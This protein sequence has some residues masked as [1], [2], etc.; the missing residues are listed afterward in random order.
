MTKVYYLDTNICIFYMRGKNQELRD[1]IDA[2]PRERIK[3][4]SV[5]K[6]ELLY[7]AEK[8][9]R[10]DATL[11]E[12]LIFCRPY[13]IVAFDDSMTQTYADIKASP[14][15]RK[16]PIGHNDT[17]IAATVMARGGMLVPNNTK[18]FGRID[19]LQLEDWTA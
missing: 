12:T 15:L 9:L 13:E 11:A 4:P 16:Q 2:I 6:A 7:G 8:S 10:H 5:V 17:L 14:A 1:R 18:E 19:G 3:I